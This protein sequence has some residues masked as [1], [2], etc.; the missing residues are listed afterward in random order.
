MTVASTKVWDWGLEVGYHTHVE[1]GELMSG[2]I[3]GPPGEALMSCS[4]ASAEI[5][6]LSSLCLGF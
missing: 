2:V 4:D 3:G 1:A 5:F 6:S